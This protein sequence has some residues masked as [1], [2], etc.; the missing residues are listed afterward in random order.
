MS[1]LTLV[2]VLW[3]GENQCSKRLGL[4]EDLEAI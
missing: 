2:S 3:A 4:L 1:C